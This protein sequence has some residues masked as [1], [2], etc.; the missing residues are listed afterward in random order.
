MESLLSGWPGWLCSAD[1]CPG[2]A[3]TQ[4]LGQ[5]CDDHP[6]GS[7]YMT[8]W[9]LTVALALHDLCIHIGSWFLI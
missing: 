3:W 1:L 6:R 8:S 7:M 5:S 4:I 2:V 9:T